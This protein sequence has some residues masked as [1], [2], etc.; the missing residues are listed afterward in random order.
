ME[1]A[2]SKVALLLC[3][4]LTLKSHCIPVLLPDTPLTHVCTLPSPRLTPSKIM[5]TTSKP[6]IN[7]CAFPTSLLILFLGWL[8]PPV[9]F[10]HS[11]SNSKTNGDRENN[12]FPL[13]SITLLHLSPRLY[14]REA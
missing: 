8:E 3:L 14:P 10:C 9:L 4:E 1:L 2:T 11:S 13:L 5:A 12:Y 7:S 6:F